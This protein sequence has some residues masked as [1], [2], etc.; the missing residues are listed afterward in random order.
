MPPKTT[1][2]QPS[3]HSRSDALD[4]TYVVYAEAPDAEAEPG[5]WPL[6]V[7]MDGDYAVDAA[8]WAYRSLREDGA[9]PPCLV[10]AVGY[11]H[12]FGSPANRRGR[13][14]TPTASPEE[15]G[16]GGADRF[17]E[18]LT[19]PLWT[20]LSNRY[21]LR[22]DIR[23]VA[24]HSLGA[25]VGLHGL[26]RG[27]RPFFNRVLAG[28][29]SIWWDNRSLLRIAS[30]HRERTPTLDARLFLGIGVMDTESMLGD[31][32]LFER[33][34]EERPYEKLV[35]NSRRIPDRDHYNAAPDLFRAGLEAL[36]SGTA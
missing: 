31:L 10:A 2:R 14:Y 15:P 11:G 7:F 33:Q 22:T 16:S 9:I 26:F 18:H 1:V 6:L 8:L 36:L 4:T 25:L 28:A 27:D 21:P 5:P 23:L 12:S 34:L 32:A 3:F 30:A 24:G 17:L 20:D 35:V 29:P 19:G 13:D